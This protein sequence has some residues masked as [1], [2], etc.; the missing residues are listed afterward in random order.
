MERTELFTLECRLGAGD[1][2]RVMDSSGGGLGLEERVGGGSRD[3]ALKGSLGRGEGGR[4]RGGRGR[5]LC[6]PLHKVTK[7]VIVLGEG[8]GER[9]RG[10]GGGGRG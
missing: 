4:G 8:R 3:R 2:R 6:G 7:L 5:S 1:D 9:V 10:S